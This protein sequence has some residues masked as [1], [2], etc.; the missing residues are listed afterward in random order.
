MQGTLLRSGVQATPDTSAFPSSERIPALDG[1]RGI[2]ISLVLL[3]HSVFQMSFNHHPA[4]N[5]MLEIGRL[6]WSGV[7]LFFVLSGFL[8]GGILLD[9]RTA[10]N[11]FKTFYLRRAYRIFPLYLLV[12]VLCWIVFQAGCYGWTP[13]GRLDLFKGH[14]PWWSFFT[15]TQNLWMARVGG[16]SGGS[17]GITWSLAIEEQFYLTLPLAIRHVPAKSLLY[18]TVGA[19]CLAPLLRAILIQ[20]FSQ[21]GFAAYVFT[22]CRADALAFGVL[23]AILVRKPG[24]W[25]L[26]G[27]H[28]I[29]LVLT[30]SILGI[31]ILWITY[32]PY[33]LFMSAL[34]GLEYTVLALFYACVLLIAVTPGR[35]PNRVFCNQILMRLGRV[36]Y[37]TYL[38]HYICINAILFVLLRYTTLSPAATYLGG[39]LLG[40]AGAVALASISWHIFERPLIQRAQMYKY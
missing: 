32:M 6:S 15:L 19:I 29:W 38:L 24:I 31:A 16:F 1:L 8:I 10:P 27:M 36:A 37:G 35:F 18:L 40:V 28:R 33:R 14:A 17:L 2:A 12:I 3:W 13:Y 30:A 7:D 25:N 9:H 11:Y 34:H 22:P 20:N 26:I 23:C 21:G 5:R 4:L 39:P